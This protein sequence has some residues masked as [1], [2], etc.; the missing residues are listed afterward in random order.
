VRCDR[1]ILLRGGDGLRRLL[2]AAVLPSVLLIWMAAT[3]WLQRAFAGAPDHVPSYVEW[4]PETI[5]AASSGDAFRGSL[6]A[7]HCEHCHGDEG[8][9]PV[10]TTPNLA[11]MDK[12]AVW[13]QLQDFRSGKRISRPMTPIAQSLSEQDVKDVVAYY[14]KLPVFADFQDNRAF[15]EA[16]PDTGQ[17]AIASRL[18]TFGDGERGIPPCDACHGPVAYR[19]GAPAL[20]TQNAN[21][22]L[23]QLEAFAS[24]RRAND[25]NEPMRTIAGLLTEDE[26]HA[27]AEYYGA[28]L[29][30]QGTTNLLSKP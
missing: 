1:R 23:D 20:M 6:L 14:S 28:G 9:S 24:G 27:L 13:K 25:I 21:Y 22:V 29:G 30:I 3:S 15:P 26:R 5:A 4:T 10:P 12:L 11:G 8:F 2:I 17:V 18:V 7:K 16:R 19:P